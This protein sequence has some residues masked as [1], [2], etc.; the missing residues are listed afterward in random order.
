[1][2]LHL[3]LYSRNVL[4][5]SEK[6]M[7]VS[8]I[9]SSWKYSWLLALLLSCVF[10]IYHIL[11]FWIEDKFHLVTFYLFGYAFLR[12]ILLDI[13]K[14]KWF[15]TFTFSA[16][17]F[18]SFYLIVAIFKGRKLLSLIVFFVILCILVLLSIPFLSDRQ[19]I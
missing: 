14:S 19:M 7:K 4:S 10:F 13:N 17:V 8:I 12:D 15:V 11:N 9:C 16:I 1:M 3:F 6:Q 5:I 2:L 18:F